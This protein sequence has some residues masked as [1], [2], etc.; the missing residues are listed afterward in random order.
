MTVVESVLRDTVPERRARVA[1]L[2]PPTSPSRFL[3]DP[4]HRLLIVAGLFVA[5]AIAAFV[6]GGSLLLHVDEPISRFLIDHRTPWLDR[7]V[8]NISFFGSTKVVLGGGAVLAVVA[9]PRCRMASALIVAATLTR[10]LLEF[11]LKLLVHRDRPTIDQMVHGAGYSFPSGHPMAAATL[12]LMVPV[13]VSLYTSSHRA[14]TVATV[15][16]LAAVL[17]IGS[18]RVYLGVHWPTDVLAG[19]LAAAMLLAGLDVLFRRLHAPRGCAGGRHT[20]C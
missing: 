19:C 8:R 12:W 13:V 18:S 10:P 14:W 5:L 6:D 7:T 11:T 16:S 2:E 9:W 1:H 3:C 17:L 4:L 20:R 15:G